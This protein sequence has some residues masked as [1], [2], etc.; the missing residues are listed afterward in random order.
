ME[1]IFDEAGLPLPPLNCEH[2]GWSLFYKDKR[3]RS[4]P[5]YYNYGFIVSP[6]QYIDQIGQ[7]FISELEII[8]SVLETVFKSQI[9][10]TI[11]F[12]R[13]GISCGTLPI[14]YNFTMNVPDDKIRVLNPDPKG[15]NSAD[16]VK[17]FHY[18]GS[19]RLPLYY[20]KEIARE[21]SKP[22]DKRDEEYIASLKKKRFNKEDFQTIESLE[23]ALRRKNL[24]EAET[25]FQRK[26]RFVHEKI[27]SRH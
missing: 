27:M 21:E 3:H 5:Y 23:G 4:C 20:N 2:T 7:S 10:N 14:N 11:C 19:K 24:S 16:D 9:A 6:K 17:I 15:E 12:E 22:K 13:H 1:K 26:L 8:D 25:V 18:L